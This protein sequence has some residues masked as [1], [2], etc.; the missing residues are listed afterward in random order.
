[1]TTGPAGPLS[2]A[3]LVR[4]SDAVGVFEHAELL[5]PRLE[6]GYCVDDVA[7]VLVVVAREPRPSD[8]LVTLARTALDFVLD[9]VTDEGL[10]HNRRVHGGGWTDT[11]G[12][13][14]CWGRA[15]WGLGT[16]AARWG[17][18]WPEGAQAAYR[19]FEQVG[20]HRS[21]DRHAM[22]FAALGA[23]EILAV[24]P[25]HAVARGLLDDAAALLDTAAMVWTPPGTTWPWPEP[26]LRYASAALCEALLAAG[27]LPGDKSRRR[28]ALQQLEWLVDLETSGSPGARHRSVT[29]AGGWEPGETR[30]AF[31][32]QP[33]EVAALADA[34][35]RAAEV[36]RTH[37][38]AAVARTTLDWEAEVLCC[39]AWFLG[40]NDV[41]V[42]L[43]DEES[44]GGYDGLMPDGRNEN[45]GAE[46][47]LA[48]LSTRQQAD[49]VRSHA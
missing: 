37:P 42:P 22:A 23:A 39:E 12:V 5:V 44:G 48:L 28:R 49:R 36:T 4:L 32:Q 13:E 33:I 30:P 6:H 2:Y 31:D 9:A 27:E 16:L 14:D 26:R 40:A 35:A 29:P 34:C 45:E 41:G 38:D 3:H 21:R 11:A 1:M 15:L 46:S 20:R 43:V 18:Q 24:R 7:R 25:R 8:E 17:D 47:T 10:V 19:G